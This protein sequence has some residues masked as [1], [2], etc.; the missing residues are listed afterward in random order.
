[1]GDSI[2]AFGGIARNPDSWKQRSVRRRA[3]AR[4]TAVL[5][6]AITSPVTVVGSAYDVVTPPYLGID[7][8]DALPKIGRWT[9]PTPVIM[10]FFNG[11]T[12]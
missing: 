11:P 2:D 6:G 12:W 7:V 9:L 4:P 5:P 3:A 8:A 1:L 10:D